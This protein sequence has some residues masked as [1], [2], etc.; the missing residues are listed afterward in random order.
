MNRMKDLRMMKRVSQ[1]AF[2][3]VA[4]LTLVL[5]FTACSND[6]DRVEPVVVATNKLMVD[7]VEKTIVRAEVLD[8][9]D[10]DYAVRFY[11][12]KDQSEYVQILGNTKQYNGK[13]IDLTKTE[14]LQET[15]AWQVGYMK[16]ASWVFVGSGDEAHQP[17]TSGT[18]QIS[19]NVATGDVVLNLVDARL[20]LEKGQN[21]DGQP[22]S[23]SFSWKGKGVI[24]HLD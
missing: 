6:D 21:S 23:I 22:H 13:T 9:K 10:D 12:S 17:F 16:S 3:V 4:A 18:M 24:T 11:L 8:M 7:N 20:H 2:A 14:E 1:V 19:V 15:I 5:G